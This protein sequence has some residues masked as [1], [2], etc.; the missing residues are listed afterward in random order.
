MSGC[1]LIMDKLSLIYAA[2]GLY[3]RL[4]ALQ[5]AKSNFSCKRIKFKIAILF[6]HVGM[7]LG[8]VG[9]MLGHVG[10]MLGHVG[11]DVGTCW[12]AAETCW[13]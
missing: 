8:H 5:M 2:L 9:M 11:G 1:C 6:G 3:K 10:M 12:D 7:L 13:G 4:R